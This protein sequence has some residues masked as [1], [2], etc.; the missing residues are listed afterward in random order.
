MEVWKIIKGCDRYRESNLGRVKSINYKNTG[1]EKVL[2]LR[3]EKSG[4]ESILLSNNGNK[5][6]FR[7]HRLVSQAFLGLD[8]ED[9]LTTVNHSNEVKTDNR[10][11]N[12]ELMTNRNNQLAYTTTRRELP[13]NIYFESNKYRVAFQYGNYR[14]GHT[15][16]CTIRLG[17]Y[18]T[19]EEA[20]FI[21]DEYLADM[22]QYKDLKLVQ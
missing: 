18:K 6:R 10:V 17:S 8:I 20:I 15:E 19:L 14:H 22:G 3:I 12:L 11:D 1:K 13:Y 21:R 9:K 4:Y 16:Y 7:V 2:S 5:K